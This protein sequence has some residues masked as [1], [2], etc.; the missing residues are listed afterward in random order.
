MRRELEQQ[1]E[2]CSARLFA[3]HAS[4]GHP[5]SDPIF[6]LGLPLAGSTLLEQILASHSQIDGTLEL[7]NI[8]ALAHRLRGR[9]ASSGRVRQPIN[10]K[11]QHAWNPSEPWLGDLKEP[12][13]KNWVRALG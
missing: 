3:R 5:A 11:D 7:P 1:Q 6:I 4:A 2:A 9:K 8:M 12:S 10:R 13:L